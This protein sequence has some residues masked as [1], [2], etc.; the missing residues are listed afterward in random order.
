MLI[1]D[2]CILAGVSVPKLLW[3][4]VPQ[5][6]VQCGS[7]PQSRQRQPLVYDFDLLPVILLGTIRENTRISGNFERSRP[8][9]RTG[10][11][12]HPGRM[13]RNNLFFSGG[14][15]RGLVRAA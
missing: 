13:G 15:K 2:S 1:G 14:Q 6:L 4:D 10:D 5:N 9:N 12:D 8:G 3:R 11:S 7:Q